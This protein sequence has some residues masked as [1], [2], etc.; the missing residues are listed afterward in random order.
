MGKKVKL[1]THDGSLNYLEEIEGRPNQY[2]LI[3]CIPDYIR[4]GNTS[5]GREFVEPSGG[6][7]I[8]VG[9]ALDCYGDTAYVVKSLSFE[10][11]IGTIVTL[12]S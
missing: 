3:S 8:V 2:K 12:E 9:S 4:G 5:D 11:G 1:Q 6:P 7:M 10:K